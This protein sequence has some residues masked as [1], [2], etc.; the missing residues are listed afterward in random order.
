[1]VTNADITIFNRRVGESREDVLIPTIIKGVSLYA[2]K[3]TTGSNYVDDSHSATIRIPANADC[4]GKQYIDAKQYEKLT[5]WSR[6]WTLQAD[7]IIVRGQIKETGLTQTDL[8]KGY[9]DVFLISGYSDNR[10][11]GTKNSHHWRVG[12]K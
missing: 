2:K 3:D 7:D 5:D 12:C 6:Y 10:S 4:S 1:M 8:T 11:R 9:D